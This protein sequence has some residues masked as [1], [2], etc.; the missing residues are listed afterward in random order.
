MRHV[1][2]LAVGQLATGQHFGVDGIAVLGGHPQAQ[3]AVVQQQVH[4]GLQRGD[5]LR[6]RQVDPA[7]VTR[8]LV[9]V[10]AQ[11]LAALQLH[12]AFGKAANAQL[13]PLQVHE[14]AQ[15]VVQLLLDLADPLVAQG[16][17]GVFAMAEVEAEDVHPGFYQLADIVDAIDR[18]AEGGEDFDFFIRRHDCAVSRIRMA[19]KS[20]TLVRV[21]SVTI[22]ASSAAK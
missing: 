6:V 7:A 9:Q 21:G 22:S 13:G 1:D 15:W 4:A 16:V 3:L 19:R 12:L 2:T 20:L 8:G 17:V 14:D 11:R 10:Q 18:R 5:D